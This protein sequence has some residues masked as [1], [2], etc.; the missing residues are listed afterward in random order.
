MRILLFI[1]HQIKLH[2][3][4]FLL[5]IG[6]LA[7]ML[8]VHSC[9]KAQEEIKNSPLP[10]DT[11]ARITVDPEHHHLR[12]QQR[13]GK[14][15]DTYLPDRPSTFE[16]KTTGEIKVS[17]AQ[18][19]LEHRFFFGA[20][21]SEAFRIGAGIDCFYWNKLDLGVGV[22]DRIGNYT[23]VVFA[24]VG[25]I[26]YSNAQVSLTYDNL[27]HVGAGISLRI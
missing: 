22:A 15:I 8:H 23:P 16:I 5:G 25:Y 2:W 11:I 20:F 19:G 24:K 7:L 6:M 13:V 10:V 27:G 4:G 18:W 1:W 26:V 3:R 14:P 17:S 9:T 21:V 12:V